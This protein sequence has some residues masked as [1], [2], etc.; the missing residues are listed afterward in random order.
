MAQAK[1]MNEA[2]FAKLVKE[3]HAVG[4]LIRARQDEKQAIIDAFNLEKKRYS[5]GKLSKKALESSVKKTNKEF[6][7]LDKELRRQIAKVNAIGTAAK[8]LASKQAP[9]VFRSKTTGISLPKKKSKKKVKKRVV[10]RKKKA[11]KKKPAKK[12]FFKRKKKVVKRKK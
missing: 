9:K 4:E 10:K 8:K 1:K 2:A 5:A 11:V 7:R 3:F 6:A 12:R